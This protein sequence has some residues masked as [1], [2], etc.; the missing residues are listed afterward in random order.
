M[1]WIRRKFREFARSFVLDVPH[2]AMLCS[3]EM[4]DIDQELLDARAQWLPLSVESTKPK[5]FVTSLR[6]TLREVYGNKVAK[7][8]SAK[9]AHA[10]GKK[11]KPEQAL[12]DIDADCDEH[13]VKQLRYE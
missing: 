4:S 3:V 1:V 11:R 10:A 6:E 8:Q 13:V 7:A 12:A 9:E 5:N 2:H